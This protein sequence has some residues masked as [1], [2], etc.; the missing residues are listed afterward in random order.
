M[1]SRLR[2]NR[3]RSYFVIQG[4]YMKLQIALDFLKRE[5]AILILKKVAPYCD[6]VEAGTPLIK[7]DSE[8][9]GYNLNAKTAQAEEAKFQA[10]LANTNLERAKELFAQD[11]ISQAGMD[12]ALAWA[13]IEEARSARLEAERRSL[14][15][16][17]R[18]ASIKALYDG[19]TGRKLVDVGEWVNPGMPVFEMVDLSRVRV[20]VDLPERYFG[21]LSSGT[22]VIII[23]STNGQSEI[24]GVVTGISPNASAEAHTFPVIIEVSNANGYLGGGMLVRARLNLNQSFT[25]LAVSKDAIIRQGNQTMIYTINE[26]TAAPI[27]VTTG[28]TNQ[29]YIAIS[30]EGIV[31]GMPI[32][33]R[34]NERIFPGSPVMTADQSE[35]QT[36]NDTPAAETSSN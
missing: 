29:D 9:S 11:L 1:K 27:P 18:N 30:G 4:K 3:S 12:S 35:A 19:Y 7:V 32:V 22:P 2:K 21:Q 25:S 6:V 20:R 13:G 28:S 14:A 8:Q 17:Y 15:V 16:N 33:V 36:V 34:G 26:G 5:D 23:A 31:E 10:G 24:P